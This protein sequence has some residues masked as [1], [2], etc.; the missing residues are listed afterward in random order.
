MVLLG[1][2]KLTNFWELMPCSLVDS[3]QRAGR[4]RC[5]L[6]HGS[7]LAFYNVRY[8]KGSWVIRLLA[9]VAMDSAV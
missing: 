2:S 6:I 9:A 8:S 4:I 3:H 7:Y 5:F 1:V